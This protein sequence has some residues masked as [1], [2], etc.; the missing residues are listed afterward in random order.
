M[1]TRHFYARINTRGGALPNP[2]LKNEVKYSLKVKVITMSTKIMPSIGNRVYLP[3]SQGGYIGK[4]IEL[5]EDGGRVL[6][7]WNGGELV[8]PDE[9][10]NVDTTTGRI[11]TS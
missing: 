9:W 7:A 4:V 1:L 8:G 10:F 6:V 2:K 3:A 5:D 11:I